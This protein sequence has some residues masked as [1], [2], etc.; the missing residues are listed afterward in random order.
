MKKKIIIFFFL[1]AINKPIYANEIKILAWVNNEIITSND[2]INQVIIKKKILNKIIYR[3][4]ERQELLELIEKKLKYQEIKNYNITIDS[5]IIEIN[6]QNLINKN[7]INNNF[8]KEN[9]YLEN[10]IKEEIKIELCWKK[11][12][13]NLYKSKINLNMFEIE[14]KIDFIDK[15]FSENKKKEIENQLYIEQRNKKMNVYSNK[16]LSM[17]QKKAFIKINEK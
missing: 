3:I 11:L 7:N 5:K 16:H 17:L 8:L 10:L 13:L 1:L 6:L 4:N 14:N 15:N 2:L 9:S 12:I